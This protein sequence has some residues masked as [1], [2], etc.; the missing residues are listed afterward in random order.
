MSYPSAFHQLQS[1]PGQ[2]FA[3]LLHASE[4]PY[5]PTALFLL[6]SL[7]LWVLTVF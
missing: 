5:A 6:A 3:P 2:G 1:G 4:A 7:E